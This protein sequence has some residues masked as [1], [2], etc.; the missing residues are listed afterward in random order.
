[1]P[2]TSSDRL[3]RLIKSLSATEKRYFKV[4]IGDTGNKG[5][6]YASL[7]DAMD[8]QTEFDDEALRR[9]IY[10]GEPMQSRKYSELK[11]YLYELVLKSLQAYDENTSIDYKLKGMLQGVRALHRRAHFDECLQILTKA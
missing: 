6:K 11:A 10:G 7:F 1:M 2:K 4:F 9:Q 8:A 3:F 5:N